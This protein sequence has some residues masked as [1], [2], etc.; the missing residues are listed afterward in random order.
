MQVFSGASGIVECDGTYA[1]KITPTDM[2]YFVG[3]HSIMTFLKKFSTENAPKMIDF[4]FMDKYDMRMKRVRNNYFMTMPQYEM[5]LDEYKVKKDKKLI[6]LLLD[7]LSIIKLFHKNKIMHRD[8]KPGNIMFNK[9]RAIL[10]DFSHSIRIRKD[11]LLLTNVIQTYTHRAP[12]IFEYNNYMNNNNNP[13]SKKYKC[14]AYDEKI[15][16]WSIGIVFIEMIFGFELWRS[17]KFNDEKGIENSF[18]SENFLPRLYSFYSKHSNRFKYRDIYWVWINKMLQK[19]PEN[20]ISAE[21][22]YNDVL[23]F[24]KEHNIRIMEPINKPI[25][26]DEVYEPSDEIPE[27]EKRDEIPGDDRYYDY[28]EKIFHDFKNNNDLRIEDHVFAKY[29]KYFMNQNIIYDYSIDIFI[30]VLTTILEISIY[31]N[32][33]DMLWIDYKNILEVSGCLNGL[34]HEHSDVLFDQYLF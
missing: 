24:A 14:P 26:D 2:F 34:F 25:Y 9:G 10:I 7:I 5:P 3:D 4:G 15:D 30:K 31:D 29:M 11:N 6:Q 27:G 18:S 17:Y 1:K 33:F 12:E 16:I 20:R 22:M 23:K 28:C 13:N 32:Y 21:D 19:L 8:I